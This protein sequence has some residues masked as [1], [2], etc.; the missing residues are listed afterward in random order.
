MAK[1]VELPGPNGPVHG[2]EQTFETARED[3][4]EYVLADGGRV[5]LKTV[6]QRIYRVVDDEGKPQHDEAG[7]PQLIVRH[8]TIVSASD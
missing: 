8:G 2:I 3:W 1:I 4:N 7:D 5:R 6:V